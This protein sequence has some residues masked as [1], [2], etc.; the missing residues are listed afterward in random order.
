MKSMALVVAA[1]LLGSVMMTAIPQSYAHAPG[2]DEIPQECLP[3]DTQKFVGTQI[4]SKIHGVS[5]ISPV[6]IIAPGDKVT[7]ESIFDNTQ[8]QSSSG[9]MDRVRFLWFKDGVLVF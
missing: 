9:I 8:S 4:L 7:V 6:G 1:V 2:V 3:P 5:V